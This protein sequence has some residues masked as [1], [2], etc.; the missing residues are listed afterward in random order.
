MSHCLTG[1]EFQFLQDTKVLETGY[2]HLDTFNIL[3]LE[4]VKMIHLMLYKFYH[5]KKKIN[6]MTFKYGVLSKFFKL[7]II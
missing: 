4:M 7:L 6:Q 5:N 3:T 2:Q 1:I